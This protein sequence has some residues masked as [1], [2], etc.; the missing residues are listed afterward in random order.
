M[1]QTPDARHRRRPGERL[2]E[3]ELARRL[4]LVRQELARPLSS[5]QPDPLFPARVVARIERPA[6]LIG[7][8]AFRALPAA[9]GLALVLARARRLGPAGG[10]RG[11][12]GGPGG[13]PARAGGG[14][15]RRQPPRD[16]GAVARGAAAGGGGDRAHPEPHLAGPQARPAAGVRPLLPGA[17]RA[18]EADVRPRPP[19][20]DRRRGGAAALRRRGA[21]RLT[22]ATG[23]STTAPRRA[24]RRGPAGSSARGCR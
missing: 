10:R 19:L 4:E 13:G 21:G 16:R 24:P 14:H 3:A 12:G 20:N 18:P 17:L 5:L 11:P 1:R 2:S 8:A 9:L 23:V 6:E 15:L 22:A 7:W